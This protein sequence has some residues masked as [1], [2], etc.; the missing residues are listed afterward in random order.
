LVS[1]A[2]RV[3]QGAAFHH[4]VAEHHLLKHHRLLCLVNVTLW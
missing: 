2:W 1:T 4:S 3:W